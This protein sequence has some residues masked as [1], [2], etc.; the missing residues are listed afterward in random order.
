MAILTSGWPEPPEKIQSIRDALAN[1]GIPCTTN[2]GE[3]G[4]L[5]VEF[6]SQMYSIEWPVTICIVKDED[7]IPPI[8]TNRASLE[9]HIIWLKDKT[10]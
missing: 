1:I 8:V 5:F 3:V 9:T 4:K 7:D 10:N 2:L 6:G